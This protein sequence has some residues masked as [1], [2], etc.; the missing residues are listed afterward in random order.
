MNTTTTLSRSNN[1]SRHSTAPAS[2][3]IFD[4]G[5]VPVELASTNHSFMRLAEERYADFA[6]PG[7]ATWQ[8]VYRVTDP[9][10]PSPRFLCDSRRQ[11]M[12]SRRRGARLELSTPTFEMALD[13]ERGIVDLAGPLATYPIDRLIQTLWYE[14]W[15][16]SLILH[17]AALAEG[18]GGWLMSGPSGSG[19]STLAALFPKHALCDEFVA[20]RLDGRAPRL[21]ALPF[22]TSRRGGAEL[23]G[24]YLLRHGRE[25]RR[26]RLT[27]GEA[28][29]RLRREVVWPTFDPA[30]LHRAFDALFDLIARVPIWELAFRPT[31]EVWQVIH[32]EP[33]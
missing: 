21:G 12:Q 26:R 11:A 30:A 7:P 28:F 17:A 5:G 23:R 32:R 2:S 18:D 6:S 9:R 13:H 8:A 33:T 4:F 10:Q 3:A 22:W 16:R 31:P 27:A 20:V 24:V 25:D 19:K 1:F 15:E 29:A 14:T